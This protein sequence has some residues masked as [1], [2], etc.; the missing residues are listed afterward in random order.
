MNAKQRAQART[1]TLRAFPVGT[2]IVGPES[3]LGSV[4]GV[5]HT[6]AQVTVRL[7]NGHRRNWLARKVKRAI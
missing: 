5:S 3:K 4:V 6:G 1:S 2:D 7:R